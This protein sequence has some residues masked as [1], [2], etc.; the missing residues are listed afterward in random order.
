MG[1]DDI[2]DLPISQSANDYIVSSI[3]YLSNRAHCM[4]FPKPIENA[5][6]SPQFC[7]A[8]IG[9]CSTA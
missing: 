1:V 5:E 4:P 3:D 7:K 9:Y 6:F 8:S 2:T